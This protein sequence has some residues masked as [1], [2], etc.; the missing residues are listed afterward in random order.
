MASFLAILIVAKLATAY[1]RPTITIP[2]SAGAVGDASDWLLQPD[3]RLS[4]A[5]PTLQ[6]LDSTTIALTNG[7][8]A[9]VF[10]IHPFFAT[11]DIATSRGS[12]LRAI[13]EEAVVSMDGRNYSVGGGVPLLDGTSA[14]CPLPVGVGPVDN[15]PTA[16]L[17]RSTLYGPDPSAFRYAGHWTSVPT[18][19][20][21]WKR[22]RHAPDMPWPPLGLRLNVNFT[23]PPD[24]TSAH[25]GV[26]VTLHYELYQ[27][28]PAMSKWLSV[29]NT[30]ARRPAAATVPAARLPRKSPLPRPP[31]RLPP[32]QQGPI[33]IQPCDAKLPPSDWESRW[34]LTADVAG[35]ITLSGSA[36]SLCLALVQGEAYHAFNDQLDVRPC[37]ASDA[38]QQW[39]LDS[40]S[41]LLLTRATAASIT[42]AFDT[43]KKLPCALPTAAPRPRKDNSQAAPPPPVDTSECVVDVNNHQA[44]AGT[45][46]AMAAHPTGTEPPSLTARWQTVADPS[47]G[48]AVRLRVTNSHYPD[49]CLW[50][51][52]LPPAPTPPAPPPPKAPCAAPDCVIL[53]SA[54]VEVLRTNAPWSPAS[55]TEATSALRANY[56]LL[57]PKVTQAHGTELVWGLDPTFDAEYS[58]NDG[59]RQPMLT[60]RYARHGYGGPSARLRAPGTE[61]SGLGEDVFES[62][63]VLTLFAD[64]AEAE[65]NGLGVRKLT[66]L[67]A[68]QTSETPQFMHLTDVTAAGVTRAVDQIVATGGGFDMIIF[69]F[70]SGFQLESTDPAYWAEIKSSVD[71]ANSHGV[72]IGGYDLIALSRTGTGYDAIDPAT[73]QS[74]GSTCFASGWNRGLLEQVLRFIGIASNCFRDCF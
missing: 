47:G 20:F 28:I 34:L 29:S 21:P 11:W 26:V 18:A 72:E 49:R 4:P 54:V 6:T 31:L 45:T 53:T 13:S 1:C 15:C 59:A 14:A 71:Y 66:R 41:G 32:S 30:G 24:C 12:A 37:N 38:K 19:P 33:C 50:H 35:P 5:V 65:R 44:D 43:S 52:P 63:R 62:F 25:A 58:G 22:M 17:N 36:P 2:A 40:T 56:G 27:G 61:G 67:L 39:L 51:T 8:L 57:H 48:E 42:A 73:G 46:L 60:A 68:P 69:S 74:A 9:R 23:A 3:P 55:P 64:S 16:Y 7:L 10:A 70:G